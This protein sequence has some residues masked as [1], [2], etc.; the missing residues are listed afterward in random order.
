MTEAPSRSSP[1]IGVALGSG[2]AHGLAHIP[3]I[4]ALDELGVRPAVIAG[5]SIGALMGAGWASGMRG[6]EIRE[7]AFNVLGTFR[8]IAGRLWMNRPTL[9]TGV[10]I[11]VDP[12]NITNAF[13]PDGFADD[14]SA[15]PIPLRAVATDLQSWE[16]AVFD[17]GPLRPA[18]AASIAI[19]A[20]FKPVKFNGRTYIDG[21]VTNPL[22]LDLAAVD[23]DIL[24]GID[25]SGT[26]DEHRPI[27]EASLVDVGIAAT[28]IMTHTMIASTIERY[29]PDIY[30]HPPVNLFGTMEFWRVREIVAAAD[31]DKDRFKRGVA[32]KIDAFLSAAAS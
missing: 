4:E 11:Q 1:R 25:V 19:P 21:G 22:P 20:M 24:I 8:V 6:G 12:L 32:T 16:P 15:L 5:T 31:A 9:K 30:V 27:A 26:P 7:H 10:S 3:Y 2:A 17:T 14:F 18:I 29:P 23:V 28:R 13:L